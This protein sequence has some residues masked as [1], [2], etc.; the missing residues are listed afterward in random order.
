MSATDALL[1]AKGV[2]G[3][4]PSGADVWS[5]ADMRFLAQAYDQL[6]RD[7]ALEYWNKVR[8]ENARLK[9]ERDELAAKLGRLT[10]NSQAGDMGKHLVAIEAEY[11]RV[12]AQRD[13]LLAGGGSEE[14]ARG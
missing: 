5:D 13:E 12:R 1:F 9:H 8:A 4:T 11:E 10:A 3:T 6:A 7:V 2:I 14:V